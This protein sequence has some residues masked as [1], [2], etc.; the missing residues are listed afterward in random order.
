[1]RLDI[2][3]IPL[4]IAIAVLAVSWL[5]PR[6]GEANEFDPRPDETTLAKLISRGV[7]LRLNKRDEQ[8]LAYFVISLVRNSAPEF[9]AARKNR[10]SQLRLIQ[11]VVAELC[12]PRETSQN[13]SGLHYDGAQA[14]HRRKVLRGL[15]VMHANLLRDAYDDMHRARRNMHA[16]AHGSQLCIISDRTFAALRRAQHSPWLMPL[17]ARQASSAT[18][19]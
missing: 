18:R 12:P 4:V 10:L 2:L 1:M 11:A 15:Y 16:E 9:D 6:K 7:R 5:F 13:S 3:A 17:L 8:R 19:T 14:D